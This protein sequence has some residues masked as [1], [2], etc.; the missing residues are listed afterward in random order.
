MN[1]TTGAPPIPPMGSGGSLRNAATNDF[2]VRLS[3]AAYSARAAI[4]MFVHDR[5]TIPHFVYPSVSGW[6]EAPV[7]VCLAY[8]SLHITPIGGG[9]KPGRRQS[10]VTNA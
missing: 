7:L 4:R 2:S 10:P 9:P 6:N 8:V 1:T 5:P 3:P